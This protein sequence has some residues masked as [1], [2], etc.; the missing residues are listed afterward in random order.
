MI[1]YAGLDL[2]KRLLVLVPEG[3]SDDVSLAE[4]VY[5]MALREHYDVLYLAFVEDSDNR[6][7]VL[8]HMATL[9]ALTA[10]ESVVVKSVLIRSDDW[11]RKLKE[12]YHSGDRIVCLAGQT[13]RNGWS[14][15]ISVRSLVEK[16]LDAPIVTLASVYHPWKATSRK[17]L[18]GLVFWLGC[19]VI[20]AG[21]SLLEIQIDRGIQGLARTA[22]IS[23]A[24]VVEFGAF[25]V[26]NHVPKI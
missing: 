1:S 16:S 13:I 5:Q 24:L 17:W 15:K 3:F 8:R 11:I 26:W 12:Y 9:S 20:L 23:I 19:L 4:K 2:K 25:W 21:F 6:M 14:K 18:Y 10:A 22:L 7:A